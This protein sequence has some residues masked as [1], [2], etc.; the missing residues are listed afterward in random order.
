MLY[1]AFLRSDYAHARIKSIDVSAALNR[2][3]VVAVYTA[4]DFGDYW[5]PGPLQVPP[6]TAIPGSVFNAR[7]LIPIAKD[8][9]RYS[10]EPLAV[11]IAESRYLAEDAFDDI[12]VDLDPLDVVT[13]LEKALQPGSPL[14][15]D[16]L[17]SNLAAHVIQQK[18]N[19][20][21]AVAQADHVYKR[22]IVVNR[23]AGAAMENRGLVVDWND[24]RTEMTVW[25]STQAPIPL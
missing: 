19:R 14:V 18:G 8:K 1:A 21:E 12:V 17:P 22:K 2:P 16:D 25:A 15:H 10:G 24:R 3:G 13:D 6:P 20:D 5:K 7:T 23:C 11:I 9:V 4:A